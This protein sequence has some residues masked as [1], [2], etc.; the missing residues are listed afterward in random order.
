MVGSTDGHTSLA[1]AQADN[2]FGKHSATEPGPE[3]P[4]HVVGQ[5]GDRRSWAGSSPKPTSAPAPRL[6][7]ATERGCR[8][9]TT[10][11]LC[12]LVRHGEARVS[13]TRVT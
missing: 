2:F 12:R 1:T 7:P 5:F 3:R 10:C 9:G 4:M 13:P 8:W 11:R 6:S